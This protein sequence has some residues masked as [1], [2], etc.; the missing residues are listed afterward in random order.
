MVSIK[1]LGVFKTLNKKRV[2]QP[3]QASPALAL[4]MIDNSK[5][6]RILL[7]L[8]SF[9]LT[10]SLLFYRSWLMKQLITLCIPWNLCLRG[11]RQFPATENEL[12]LLFLV[13]AWEL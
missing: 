9:S 8:K 2:Y 6:R 11:L 13:N 10:L 4:Q 1:T 3:S 7:D 5:A 12:I